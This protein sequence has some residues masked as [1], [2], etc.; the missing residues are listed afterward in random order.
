MQKT[1]IDKV[2]VGVENAQQLQQNLSAI[3]TGMKDTLP[4]IEEIMPASILMPSSWPQ[5]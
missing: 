5:L 4:V 1:F 2:I 3:E